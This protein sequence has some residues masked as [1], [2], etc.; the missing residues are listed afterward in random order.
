MSELNGQFV[1]HGFWVNLKDGPVMGQ[2]F[3]TTT[4]NGTVVVALLAVLSSLATTHLWHLITFL[5]HQFRANGRPADGL[6]RQQQVILRTLPAPSSLMA[7]SVKV[8]WA[9]RDSNRAFIRCLPQFL[10]ATTFTL[11]TV[12]AGIFSSFAVSNENL[13]VLVQSPGCGYINRTTMVASQGTNTYWNRI[14]GFTDSYSRACYSAENT[15]ES[16]CSNIF[17]EP[18]VPFSKETAACPFDES[19]C[20]GEAISLDSGL[21]HLNERLGM[22]LKKRDRVQFRKKTTCAVLPL[23]GHSDVINGSDYRPLDREPGLDDPSTRGDVF[24]LQYGDR[25]VVPEN[26][27]N[28]TFAFTL[29]NLNATKGFNYQ[30]RFAYSRI[31]DDPYWVPLPGMERKDADVAVI[32]AITNP[33]RY[34][35]PVDDP[36][37]AAHR[38]WEGVVSNETFTY[39]APDAPVGVIG[40]TEQYQFCLSQGSGKDSCT[41]LAGLTPPWEVTKPNFPDASG[42]QLA[43]LKLLVRSSMAFD[44]S[45]IVSFNAS[46]GLD[47]GISTG[48]PDDQW[49]IEVEG[50]AANTWTSLQTMISDYAI[51]AKSHD[52]VADSYIEPPKTAG[53]RELC[54]VQKMRKAGGFANVNVFALALIIAVSCT[55]TILD[56]LLLRFLIFLSK[57]RSALAPRINRWIQDG[58]LQLQRRAYE[59]LGEGKWKDLEGEI[60]VT[61]RNEVLSDLAQKRRSSM[62]EFDFGRSVTFVEGMSSTDNVTNKY[63]KNKRALDS[64]PT[65]NFDGDEK[66]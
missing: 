64:S 47:G 23:E 39:Y 65:I 24:I 57:F 42:T 37:F 49:I 27:P 19:M 18:H 48:L 22:N 7:D 28:A 63:G 21:S 16:Q 40:C 29:A 44:I 36:V 43:V 53:E 5:I 66:S 1:K 30:S 6:F 26:W 32:V 20:V 62:S 41:E 11:A 45:N 54:Q 17:I 56:I 59:A 4:R 52:P 50:W 58:V 46:A 13:E 25:A 51:G 14:K 9:W 8:Y 2:T 15:L 3:T 12:S 31:L 61:S 33:N 38:P 35:H 34:S 60:P 10:L 55:V